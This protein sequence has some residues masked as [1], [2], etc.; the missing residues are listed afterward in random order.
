MIPF[1]RSAFLLKKTPLID[2]ILALI[3]GPAFLVSPPP[4]HADAPQP[5]LNVGDHWTYSLTGTAS[6]LTISVFLTLRIV[7]AETV[8]I[9]GNTYDTYRVATSGSGSA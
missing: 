2:L 1:A 5:T 3:L 8:T 9:A 6:G 7:D 4:A